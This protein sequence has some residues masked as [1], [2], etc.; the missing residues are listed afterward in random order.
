MVFFYRLLNIFIFQQILFQMFYEITKLKSDE[1]FSKAGVVI[2]QDHFLNFCCNVWDDC[3]NRQP[4]DDEHFLNSTTYKM[5]NTK[6]LKVYSVFDSY[7][8]KIISFSLVIK[9]KSTH[10]TNTQ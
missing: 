6:C 1:Y 9:Y 7:L 3:H 8:L 4:T 2:S 5:V 10:K